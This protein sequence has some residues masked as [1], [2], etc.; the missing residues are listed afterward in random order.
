MLQIIFWSVQKSDKTTIIRIISG[1]K[2]ICLT[3]VDKAMTKINGLYQKQDLIPVKHSLVAA[4]KKVKRV[5]L[6]LCP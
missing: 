4:Q 1:T 3:N 2:E 5:E 6:L